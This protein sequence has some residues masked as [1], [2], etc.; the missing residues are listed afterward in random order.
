[1]IVTFQ[2]MLGLVIIGIVVRGLLSAIKTGRQRPPRPGRPH[3]EMSRP[4]TVQPARE[5][6]HRISDAEDAHEDEYEEETSAKT[7]E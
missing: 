7:P 2:M 3:Q 6:T 4:R 5:R 1:M